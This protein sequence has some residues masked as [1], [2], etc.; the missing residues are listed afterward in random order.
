MTIGAMRRI[1]EI[2]RRSDVLAQRVEAAPVAPGEQHVPLVGILVN[3]VHRRG[4][5]GRPHDPAR[6]GEARHL[7]AAG[8]AVHRVDG[9]AGR[10]RRPARIAPQVDVQLTAGRPAA[11]LLPDE[12]LEV[13]PVGADGVDVVPAVADRAD[14]RIRQPGRAVDRCLDPVRELLP[15]CLVGTDEPLR[16]CGGRGAARHERE[17]DGQNGESDGIDD[18]WAKHH[19]GDVSRMRS[20]FHSLCNQYVDARVPLLQGVGDI[21]DKRAHLDAPRVQ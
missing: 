16:R 2:Q 8:L 6:V 11:R 1:L 13:A 7:R 12:R 21:A 14:E 4:D 3:R 15:A 9:D 19:R 10:D 20:R 17:R 18:L 5:P